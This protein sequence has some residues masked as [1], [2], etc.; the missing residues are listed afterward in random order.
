VSE[1][2]A[3]ELY[4][5]SE[6]KGEHVRLDWSGFEEQFNPTLM[7]KP[8]DHIHDIVDSL[9]WHQ[10][11]SYRFK[12]LSHVNLQEVRAVKA[13]VK[14]RALHSHTPQRIVN[15]VDSRVAL[16]CICKGRSSSVQL[17]MLLR[18]FVPYLVGGQIALANIWV[19]THH[20][21][22]DDPTRH[23]KVRDACTPPTYLP[24]TYDDFKKHKRDSNDGKQTTSNGGAIATVSA[25]PASPWRS[26][27]PCLPVT[28]TTSIKP[29][30][31]YPIGGL[32]AGKSE[33][34]DPP[35]KAS[36]S[37]LYNDIHTNGRGDIV[38]AHLKEA[39]VVDPQALDSLES[40]GAYLSRDKNDTRSKRKQHYTSW[41][42][43]PLTLLHVCILGDFC[44][45]MYVIQTVCFG[46]MESVRAFG[47]IYTWLQT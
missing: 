25:K 26:D 3:E 15:F 18:S 16:G 44:W 19:G 23:Q 11:R 21:P 43:I 33:G 37:A 47:C 14:Y 28:T 10:S 6:F 20:N 9:Q 17:N 22:G 31:T 7:Q 27:Q 34:A 39:S 12:T 36:S 46:W 29:K 8:Q 41:N 38:V 24:E 42:P 5:A 45:K 2:L 40:E 30:G 4:K 13:E 1:Q 35:R 32:L